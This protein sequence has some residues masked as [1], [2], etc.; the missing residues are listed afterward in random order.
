M[1]GRVT[2]NEANLDEIEANKP[3]RQKITEPKTPYHPMIDDDGSMSPIHDFDQCMGTAAH[4]E[5]ILSALN[6]VSSSSR[7]YSKQSGGWAAFEDEVDSMEQGGEDFDLDE[8][9]L[10]FKEQRRVH[11]DEYRMVKELQRK[12]SLGD[13]AYIDNGSCKEMA[14]KCDSSSSLTGGMRALDMEVGESLPSQQQQE[15]SPNHKERA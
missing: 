13:A 1:S 12:G 6:D 10:S 7:K 4:A 5:A 9:R 8:D 3:V 14:E 2:W 11:Y 15:P